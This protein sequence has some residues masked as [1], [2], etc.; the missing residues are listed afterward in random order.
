MLLHSKYFDNLV[1]KHLKIKSYLPYKCTLK[2][3]Q[4]HNNRKKANKSP[5]FWKVKIKYILAIQIWSKKVR[6]HH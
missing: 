3:K 5:K 2:P 1:E 6:T 4:K